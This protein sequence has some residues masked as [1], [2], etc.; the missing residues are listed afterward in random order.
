MEDFHLPEQNGCDNSYSTRLC[1]KSGSGGSLVLEGRR[2]SLLLDVVTSE[3]VDP[4]LDE[5]ESAVTRQKR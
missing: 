2:K 1:D 5:N 3:T 4:G